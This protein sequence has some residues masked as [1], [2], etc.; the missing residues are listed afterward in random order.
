MSTWPRIF[1]GGSAADA[2]TVNREN[3]LHNTSGG[4]TPSSTVTGPDAFGASAAAGTA[5]TYARGDHDHGLPAA[6][7]VPSPSGTVTGPDAFGAS[8]VAGSAA[9]YA[10]GDH[11]HGLPAAPAVPSASGTVVGP[12]AFGA[13]AAAGSA[14]A[15]AR[16]DHD[17][18]LPANPVTVAK[19]ESLFTA[20][21]Q[22]FSGTGNGTG[23]LIDLLTALGEYYADD[24]VY[25][26]SGA[27]TGALQTLTN[28]Y[29]IT[30]NDELIPAVS[31]SNFYTDLGATAKT[32]TASAETVILTSPSLAIGTWQLSFTLAIVGGTAAGIVIAGYVVPTAAG[33]AT[34]TFPGTSGNPP[35]TVLT[36]PTAV[37]LD[38]HGILAVTVNNVVVT[39]AGTLDVRINAGA[40]TGTSQ[41]EAQ[42]AVGGGKTMQS[43]FFSG[44][45]TA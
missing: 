1:G 36:T 17:H 2:E 43:S 10:R 45:R 37:A 25:V 44:V 8:A 16:G 3:E 15:Y 20:D 38:N 35:G 24:Q 29:G 32:I 28:G 5:T 14:T 31:L 22:V 7:S 42:R 26:G 41:V 6:P 13:A 27:G 19:I 30:G 12:D 23:E 34:V 40:L 11:D 9:T 4:G 21:Q 33:G 39:V 18:G